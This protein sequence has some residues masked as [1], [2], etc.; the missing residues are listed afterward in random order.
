M[1]MWKFAVAILAISSIASAYSYISRE[2]DLKK[3]KSSLGLSSYFNNE[4]LISSP[5]FWGNQEIKRW[6]FKIDGNF[7]N[8]S[9]LNKV[10]KNSIYNEIDSKRECLIKYKFQE[11]DLSYI[12]LSKLGKY[13]IISK[14][15]LSKSDFYREFDAERTTDAGTSGPN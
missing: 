10:I 8:Y 7:N 15:Y 5:E 2:M 6:V 4:E 3:S 11:S 9:C 12:S 14:I 1:K 13:A